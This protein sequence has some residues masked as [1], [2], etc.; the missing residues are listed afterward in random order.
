MHLKKL[1]TAVSLISLAL[2]CACGTTQ[3]S[4]SQTLAD[5]TAE[6]VVEYINNMVAE[7][8]NIFIVGM[9]EPTDGDYSEIGVTAWM[10][11]KF[12]ENESGTLDEFQLYW[13]DGWPDE[14][15]GYSAG[16]YIG[17]L[18]DAFVPEIQEDIANTIQNQTTM[19]K[20]S[21]NSN[22]TV[23]EYLC[24][25]TGANYLTFSTEKRYEAEENGTVENDTENYSD[26]AVSDGD[27]NSDENEVVLNEELTAIA[28]QYMDES[29]GNAFGNPTSWYKYIEN[30]LIY[31]APN[32][33]YTAT[34]FVSSDCQ[35]ADTIGNALMMNF[36]EV[37]INY[38]MVV[39][40]AGN[41]LFDRNNP[42]A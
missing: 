38:V 29:F 17:I 32:D 21:W 34:I 12:E 18:T 1:I 26:A 30:I 24:S 9:D 36:D 31:S 41:L 23:V 40:D 13:F 20:M 28:T 3:T 39:D 33:N 15:T 14:E 4:S 37:T 16:F 5:Y 7:A 8:D 10:S 2:L 25:G 27:D 19:S 6:S 11:M 35:D 42:L 22:D